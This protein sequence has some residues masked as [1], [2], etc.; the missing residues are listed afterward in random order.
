MGQLRPPK[1]DIK[2]SLG[3]Q[4]LA[5]LYRRELDAEA[6]GGTALTGKEAQTMASGMFWIYL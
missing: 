6:L 4:G 5:E 3:S 2:G 1:A